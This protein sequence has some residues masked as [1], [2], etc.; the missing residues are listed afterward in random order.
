MTKVPLVPKRHK[1]HFFDVKKLLLPLFVLMASISFAQAG[2]TWTAL[3]DMPFSQGNNAVTH[4]TVNGVSHAYTFSGVDSTKIW[5]GINLRAARYNTQTQVW[6]SIASLPDATGK[7]GVGA[8]AVNNIIYVMGGYHVASNGSETSSDK[9]HRYD[10]E[11]NVYLS[12]GATIPLAIDDHV[13][14]VWRDSLIFVVTGWSNTG[15]MPDVQIYD[16][17]NDTWALGT[18]VPNNHDYKAFGASGTIVGDTIYY[19]G[20]AAMGSNFASRGHLRKGVIDPTDPTQITWSIPHD[21]PGDKGYRMACTHYN[22]KV[23]WIGGSG[24]TYNYNGVAYNGTGGVE[25]VD[26]ILTYDVVDTTW[27][28]GYGAPQRVMDLRGIAQIAPTQWII[29]GG[30]EPGQVVSKKAWLLEY[31]AVAGDLLFSVPEYGE[32]GALEFY[33]NP[34]QNAIQLNNIESGTV[35]IFNVI[36]DL[37]LSI[38]VQEAAL[39]NLDRLAIGVYQIVYTHNTSIQ[40]GKLIKQ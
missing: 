15:N 2:W 31:D 11:N 34:A 29:C 1:P 37:V 39:I 4:G 9:V 22:E 25:P 8:S 33:P 7:I 21:N 32:I 10:P 6:E 36:G 20:G 23:F 17:S 38:E 16:P 3:P 12:D 5:S 18:D 14:A 27:L 13:Q 28:Q 35:E 24:T 19:N 40:M 26:R 30:M